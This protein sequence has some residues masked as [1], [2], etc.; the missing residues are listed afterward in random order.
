[1]FNWRQTS[2]GLHRSVHTAST[3]WTLSGALCGGVGVRCFRSFFSLVVILVE[4]ISKFLFVVLLIAD[5][6]FE[7]AL[8]GAE[9]DGLAV[10]ASHHVERRLGFAAQGQLQQVRLN[11]GLDG[12]AQLGL[13]LEEAVRRTHAFNALIGPLVVIVFDPEFDPFPRRLEAVELGADEE[14]LPDG[15]PEAF[16]LAEGHG[17]M[18]AGFDVRHPILL[19]F[20]LEPAGAAP[21]GVLAAVV[22][23]HLLG[24]LELAGRHAIHFDHR[25]GRG[26]AEQIRAHNE[27]RVIIHERD[28]VG[29]TA[30]QPEREDV[31]LPHL[32]GCG[33]LKEAGTNHIALLA[34]RLLGHQLGIMQPL[35]HRLGAGR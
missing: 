15:G 16:H 31:R 14:V 18:R 21:T 10:H 5:T 9:H 34:R 8:L 17:M 20:G 4:V 25:V 11:A 28:E 35:P 2:A 30:A 13:D 33:P 7:F 24:R 29:V 12:F 19:Q 32:I 1:M 23:E 22:G 26:T 6:E 27:P 3:A